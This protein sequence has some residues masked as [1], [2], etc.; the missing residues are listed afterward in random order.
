MVQGQGLNAPTPTGTVAFSICSPSQLDDP[1]TLPNGDP[2]NPNT[3]D[4]GGTAVSTNT[5]TPIPNT[6][7]S[8]A[9]SDAFTPNVTGTWCWRGEYSG[10]D[11]YDPVADSS[12]G[13]CFTVVDAQIDVSPSTPPTR[14]AR[15]TWSRRRC[16]RTPGV[17]SSMLLTA[18]R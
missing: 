16:S 1:G 7:N 12:D 2:D 13:E 6:T 10:D 18:R 14:R 3:C 8:Q 9:I 15:T 11:F 17:A 4:L 5:L